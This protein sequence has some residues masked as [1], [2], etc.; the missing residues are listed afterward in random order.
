MTD[1]HQN[2]PQPQS[3]PAQQPEQTRAPERQ[4]RSP[5]GSSETQ[6]A[7]SRNA[8]SFHAYQVLYENHKGEPFFTRVGT[9]WPHSDGKG[10]NLVF[11]A[12]PVDGRAEL[13]S[14]QA[15]QDG[16]SRDNPQDAGRSED[17]PTYNAYQVVESGQGKSFFNRIGK[18]S[19]QPG[20]QPYLFHVASW[21]TDGRVTLRTVE[22]RLRDMRENRAPQR[23]T[24][25]E[26]ER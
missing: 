8:P 13:H 1:N 18:A 25:K 23:D 20:D 19:P 26:R 11:N 24:H 12:Q 21:P 5:S 16:V 2:D 10:H 6:Q 3:R 17:R 14:P 9:G 4:E 22:D 15:K 7:P